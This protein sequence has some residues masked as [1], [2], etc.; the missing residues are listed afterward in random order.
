MH[1][2]KTMELTM[3]KTKPVVNKAA[4]F[5]AVLTILMLGS[6][7]LKLL[8]GLLNLLLKVNCLKLQSHST[9]PQFM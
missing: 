6:L 5:L 8:F 9:E 3:A 7:N 1:Q 2:D 4:I